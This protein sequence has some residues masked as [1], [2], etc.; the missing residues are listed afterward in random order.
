MRI[1]DKATNVLKRT[2]HVIQ[3]QVNSSPTAAAEVAE[4]VWFKVVA[5]RPPTQNLI[6]KA[7]NLEKYKQ[8]A[9]EENA[10][11]LEINPKTGYYATR[12]RAGSSSYKRRSTNPR[13]LFTPQSITFFEDR[14]R[15][16]FYSQH[17]W[18][19]ARP[20]LVI[21]TDGKDRSRQDWSRMDQLSKKLDGESVVQR[22]LYL[23]KNDPDFKINL[24]ETTRDEEWI[25]AYEKAR[26][27]FTRLRI[28]EETRIQVAMEEAGMF[29]AVFGKTDIEKGIEKEQEY[30]EKW[31]KEAIEETKVLNA[32]RAAPGAGSEPEES[33]ALDTP[34]EPETTA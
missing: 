20:K 18:E 23:L 3:S 5:Q 14:I 29:G 27:E 16:L 19:L 12:A 6:L 7:H 8:I 21:E 22:T 9:L 13:H 25:G 34:E 24:T 28:R 11:S 26:L 30:I 4:P 32:R 2:A 15:S 31:R 1:Q 17:P 33:D 10:E